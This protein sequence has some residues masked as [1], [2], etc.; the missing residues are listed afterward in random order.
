MKKS[1]F[2]VFINWILLFSLP[3]ILMTSNIETS[4]VN[5]KQDVKNLSTNLFTKVEEKANKE[6]KQKIDIIDDNSDSEDDFLQEVED[7]ETKIKEEQAKIEKQ[8]EI[9][10]ELAENSEPVNIPTENPTPPI[11][12]E[13]IEEVKSDVLATYSGNMS[14]YYANCTGCSGITSTG[15]D[16]SDGSIYYND[17]QYGNV[18]IIAAGTEIKKWSI[19]RIKNSSLGGSVLAIVLDRGGDIGQNKR[20]LVDMLTNTSESRGGVDRGITVEV[21]RSGK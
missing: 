19:V 14:F 4:K 2:V 20:F 8:E 12:E 7:K 9:N 1:K 18:R 15:V 5:T 13:V 16:V 10:S 21:L 3:V 11:V 6:N 17:K